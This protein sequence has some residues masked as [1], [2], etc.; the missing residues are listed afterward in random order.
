MFPIYNKTS[1]NLCQITEEDK[2]SICNPIVHTDKVYR[3]KTYSLKIVQL[4][5]GTVHIKYN[6]KAY[7]YDLTAKTITKKFKPKS[8]R[9]H[10]FLCFAQKTGSKTQASSTFGSF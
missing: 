7:H 6:L 3:V 4:L 2:L 5:G 1:S 8:C 9:E 10:F